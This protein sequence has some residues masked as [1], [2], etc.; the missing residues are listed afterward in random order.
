MNKILIG[1]FVTTAFSITHANVTKQGAELLLVSFTLEKDK[2]KVKLLKS[3]KD[4][5]DSEIQSL[6]YYC[7]MFDTNLIIKGLVN[8][9]PEL[10]LTHENLVNSAYEDEKNRKKIYDKYGLKYDKNEGCGEKVQIKL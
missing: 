10:T 6:N 9:Y 8:K 7:N 1:L 2:A 4:G 3:L 5:Y